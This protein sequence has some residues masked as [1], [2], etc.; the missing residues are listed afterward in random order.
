MIYAIF[1]ENHVALRISKNPWTFYAFRG[2]LSYQSTSENVFSQF[3]PNVSRMKKS[4]E[5][6]KFRQ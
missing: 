1:H 4:R 6:T 2:A 3:F 5:K